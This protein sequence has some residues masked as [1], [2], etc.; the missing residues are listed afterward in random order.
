MTFTEYM[1]HFFNTLIHLP[2]LDPIGCLFILFFIM[3]G[4]SLI[5]DNMR[6]KKLSQEFHEKYADDIERIKKKRESDAKKGIVHKTT[7]IYL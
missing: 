3:M 2:Q 7:G 6:I 5:P 1:S 4:L